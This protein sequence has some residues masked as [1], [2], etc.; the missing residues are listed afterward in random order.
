MKIKISK[1]FMNTLINLRYKWLM[2]TYHSS[3]SNKNADLYFIKDF[4]FKI[5]EVDKKRWFGLAK[6]KKVTNIYLT[7]LIIM[8]YAT[9]AQIIGSLTEKYLTNSLFLNNLKKYRSTYLDYKIQEKEL[10]KYV[11]EE[12]IKID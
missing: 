11:E 10:L 8:G 12:Q 2:K 1:E 9:D 5:E 4:T 7:R 6:P 3:F